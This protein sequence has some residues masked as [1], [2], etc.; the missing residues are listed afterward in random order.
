MAAGRG[1]GAGG[2]GSPRIPRGKF[3]VPAPRSRERRSGAVWRGAVRCDAE[4]LLVEAGGSPQHSPAG[5]L[6][7]YGA[8]LIPRCSA[9]LLARSSR[10]EDGG[11]ILH[12]SGRLSRDIIS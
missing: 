8:S 11:F 3:S 4:A 10:R 2:G 6:S 5:P 12:R 9:G 7:P 1:G